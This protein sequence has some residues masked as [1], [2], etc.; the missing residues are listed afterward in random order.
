MNYR[1]K[2]LSMAFLGK[3]EGLIFPK[4]LFCAKNFTQIISTQYYCD[5]NILIPIFTLANHHRSVIHICPT[6]RSIYFSLYFM[7]V[8]SG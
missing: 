2:T 4:H 5:M 8:K 1:N 6:S 3:K 7:N